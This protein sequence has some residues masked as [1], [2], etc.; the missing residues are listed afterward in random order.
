MSESSRAKKFAFFDVDD[1]VISVKSMLSF[2]DFWYRQFP[3]RER[4]LAYRNDLKTHMRPNACWAHLNRLYY[5]HFAGRPMHQVK[6]VAQQWFKTMR[7]D[8]PHFYHQNVL[9]RLK[10]HQFRGETP[11][12]VSGSFRQLL[13]PIAQELR[14]EHILAIN[15][16]TRD[17]ICTG[18]IHT[19]QTIGE[20]KATAISRFLQEQ[21][22]S[23]E[24]CFAY[25]DDISDLPMLKL[26]GTA[27]VVTGGRGLAEEAVNHG[28]ELVNP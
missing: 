27:R 11:V 17:G 8:L 3:D 2:Q 22:T 23:P 5:R 13:E 4:E 16:K 10:Q 21:E 25:G 14:I 15:M 1:T 26:V 24:L 6:N 12:F 7:H 28:W 18:E 9:Q 20:G 19:P